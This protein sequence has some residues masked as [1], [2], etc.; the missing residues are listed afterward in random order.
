MADFSGGAGPD[1]VFGGGAAE[2]F[3]YSQGGSDTV[4]GGGGDDTIYFGAEFGSGDQ[5]NGEAGADVLELQGDYSGGL[6]FDGVNV[7]NVETIHFQGFSAPRLTVADGIVG[8]DETLTLINDD[9]VDR[10][11]LDGRA[12]LH[13][14]L[15]VTTAGTADQHVYGGALDDTLTVTNGIDRSDVYDLGDGFDTLHAQGIFGRM[16]GHTFRN[17]EAITFAGN[18][19][20][21]LADGSVAA[22]ETLTIT[23]SSAGS[24]IVDKHERDG[25]L[26]MIGDSGVDG[27]YAGWG[28]DTLEGGGGNDTLYG[29]RGADVLSGGAGAD[30]FVY[31][32]ALQSVRGAADLITD[33]DNSDTIS[34]SSID[35]DTTQ[36]GQQFFTLVGSLDHHAGELTFGYD[37]E[38]GYT[39]LAG[40]L[41]GD[42]K[43]DFVVLIEGDHSDFTGLEF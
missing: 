20:V 19:S 9:S 36:K 18:A 35:A 23:T 14:A 4:W 43:A 15:D 40:D 39:R 42:A 31:T 32:K 12:L 25:A 21:T 5:V 24:S 28:A 10:F 16:A 6:V 3:D 29:N 37:P 1:S 17:I 11:V 34:L 38:T 41:D 13:T 33:L 2:S 26:H 8:T 30:E 7:I 27:F 22:G